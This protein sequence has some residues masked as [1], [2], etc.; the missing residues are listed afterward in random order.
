MI[1]APVIVMSTPSTQY[2]AQ[3]PVLAHPAL[4][5]TTARRFDLAHSIAN[6]DKRRSQHSAK[7]RFLLLGVQNPRRQS[8]DARLLEEVNESVV[9]VPSDKIFSRR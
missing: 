2:P 4:S 8:G 1:T 7:P 6:Q 9:I 3:R 5:H